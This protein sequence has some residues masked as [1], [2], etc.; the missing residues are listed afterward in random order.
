MKGKYSTMRRH[1]Q[2]KEEW[3]ER[4]ECFW[5]RYNS[6]SNRKYRDRRSANRKNGDNELSPKEY[7]FKNFLNDYLSEKF[8]NNKSPNTYD[9]FIPSNLKV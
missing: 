3:K 9:L 8:E 5:I 6:L 7:C 2:E 4:W 1:I